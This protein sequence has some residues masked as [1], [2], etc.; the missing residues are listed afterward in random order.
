MYSNKAKIGLIAKRILK[1]TYNDTQN[2]VVLQ[3]D[4]DSFE[5]IPH[6]SMDCI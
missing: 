3:W 2:H 1:I 6:Q 4:R 5:M